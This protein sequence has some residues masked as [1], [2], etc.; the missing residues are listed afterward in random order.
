[1]SDIEVLDTSAPSS[2]SSPS[3][4]QFVVPSDLFEIDDLQKRLKLRD[5]WE[6]SN[7]KRELTS[8]HLAVY[9]PKLLSPYPDDPAGTTYFQDAWATVDGWGGEN[10]TVTA[11]GGG[12]LRGV[13]TGVNY[14]VRRPGLSYSAGSYTIRIRVR[15]TAG[16]VVGNN[17]RIYIVHNSGVN[18]F[19]TKYIKFTALNEWVIVDATFT[20]L[21][22]ITAIGINNYGTSIGDTI[23]IDWIYIG[24][25][26][27]LPG[28]LRDLTGNGL[29]C[30]VYGSTPSGDSLIRD[31]IN[32]YEVTVNPVEMPDKFWY[33]ETV[34]TSVQA[35]G[36]VLL[37]TN[38]TTYRYQIQRNQTTN[39]LMLVY[40]DGSGTQA[41]TEFSN[42]FGV[43]NEVCTLDFVCDFVSKTVSVY[44]NGTLFESRSVP[45]IQKPIPNP[46][47]LYF[48]T[49]PG[50]G[51]FTK[52]TFSNRRLLNII[53]TDAQVRWLY[54]NPKSIS[55]LLLDFD[56]T[57]QWPQTGFVS[58]RGWWLD[59]ADGTRIQR[60]TVNVNRT[61]IANANIGTYG[62]SYYSDGGTWT[63]P[64]EFY[65]TD[66]DVVVGASGG[67]YATRATPTVSSVSYSAT[68][69]SSATVTVSLIAVGRW[70]A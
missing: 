41:Q 52:G 17:S 18:L 42:Y 26:A 37:G 35:Y 40:N 64:R 43:D 67:G 57:D 48:G 5:D 38:A 9:N 69:P 6:F 1:M 53:P 62:W 30:T 15:K 54:E 7:P 14:N 39:T 49:R 2:I 32:D 13:S 36:Q 66:I 10:A 70:K 28:T 31:G 65:S 58:G 33:H 12:V 51:L 59:L 55:P 25:G 23:E 24:T 60:F 44:K 3:L 27:Y 47:L 46:T 34:Q 56:N 50:A 16:A 61:T 21:V 8:G 29:D 63:F 45:L 20:A 68:G 19:D 22:S 4:D 11:P